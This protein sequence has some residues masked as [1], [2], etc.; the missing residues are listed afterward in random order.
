L[1]VLWAQRLLCLK[2]NR[3]PLKILLADDSL[4]AQNMGKKILTDA[5]YEVIAVSN[6]AQAMKKI[7]AERPDLVVLDVYMPG[8]SGLEVCERMRNSR[9]TAST[10]VLLSVGKMEPFQHEEGSRVRADAVI[11]KPFEAT[12]LVAMLKKLAENLAPV[13]VAKH[14]PKPAPEMYADNGFTPAEAE[15]EIQ[16]YAVEIPR[17]FASTPA[18]GMDLIPAELHEPAVPIAP[19]SA[20]DG[21]M[22][23]EVE[24]DSEPVK[25][26]PGMRMA[27]A[28]GLSGVFEM[29]PPTEPAV[30][31]PLEPAPAEEFERFAPADTTPEAMTPTLSE[32][33]EPTTLANE[34]PSGEP[35]AFAGELQID[36]FAPASGP[37]T[38][39]AAE[40]GLSEYAVQQFDHGQP[41]ASTQSADSQAP[42][43]LPELTSWNEPS[44]PTSQS[45][46][47]WTVQQPETTLAADT[48]HFPPDLQ[49]GAA[50]EHV[51]AGAVW[52]AEEAEIEPHE[53]AIHLHE[54]MQRETMVSEITEPEP[55]A[56][57]T[58]EEAS[59][60]SWEAPEPLA[61]EPQASEPSAL[62]QTEIAPEHDSFP[63]TV[64]SEEQPELQSAEPQFA[65][66]DFSAHLE[67]SAPDPAA[68]PVPVPDH[69]PSNPMPEPADYA[70]PPLPEPPATLPT[71]IEAPV[72]PV[73]VARIVDQL[74]ERLKPE[75]M[76]AVV[77]ELEHKDS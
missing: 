48:S 26:D 76:A 38:W 49:A 10:P 2:G 13:P 59:F 8:Y 53:S 75:L 12:E 4:T 51:P 17:E 60:E 65:S 71:I 45:P 41:E 40:T 50:T 32:N 30:Q 9:E 63:A 58:M 64:P 29:T 16:R 35:Q 23:F 66:T 55:A 72:D 39:L 47:D 52:I 36:S 37:E 54:Q 31:S 61:E 77:R 74:I 44:I 7:V 33:A 19:A 68:E 11:V 18:I 24:H 69:H 20:T 28:A 70:A 6:G 34:F 56:S 25:I 67:A 3:V 5:G 14:P 46:S 27:S 21:P 22:D 15:I 1:K 73:R 42:Q 62:E 57:V 43:A